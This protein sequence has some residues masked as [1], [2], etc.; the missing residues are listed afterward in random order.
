[1]IEKA[2]TSQFVVVLITQRSV[3]Q[4]H[5]PQPKNSGPA[6]THGLHNVPATWVTLLARTDFR[7]V[8]AP[9]SP[10]RSTPDHT[11]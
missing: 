7:E 9:E 1:M 5:P 2:K 3:V 8:R 6:R 10:D 11:A 4:I